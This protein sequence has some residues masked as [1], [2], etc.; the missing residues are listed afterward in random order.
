M[1]KFF[2]DTSLK[3]ES[4]REI[5]KLLEEGRSVTTVNLSRTFR[6]EFAK[7]VIKG[8]FDT[9]FKSNL[10]FVY[11]DLSFSAEAYK[12]QLQAALSE[13][14]GKH[15]LI[16]QAQIIG[17]KAIDVVVLID[18]CQVSDIELFKFILNLRVHSH[19]K[20]RFMF[21]FLAKDFY[22]VPVDNDIGIVYEN[23]IFV[24]Y[25][26][27]T[28]AFDWLDLKS[29]K[30]IPEK[31][32]EDIFKITGGAPKIIELFIRLIA[33]GQ[34]IDQILE[35]EEFLQAIN[36]LWDRFT[37]KEKLVIL[38]DKSE[39][40]KKESEYLKKLNLI[41][42]KG[43]VI[44]EWVRYVTKL[45]GISKIGDNIVI[46]GHN[47]SDKIT[48]REYEFLLELFE[49]TLVTKE[50]AEELLLSEI[51]QDYSLWAVDQAVKRLRDK[52]KGLGLNDVII[53]TVKGKGYQLNR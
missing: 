22:K 19:E 26:D 35:S 36:L 6:T 53:K 24:P 43:R 17:E 18:N 5:F 47:L 41:D 42:D 38:G 1:T 20:I 4:A 8:D 31:L 7:D 27:K 14:A 50:K 39:E 46:N 37:A 30:K 34:N 51:S 16:Q 13:Y 45:N 32:K 2:E 9:E 25:L 28:S 48:I 21:M 3:I 23:I 33:K 12:E 49:S 15:E 44:G 11:S 29:G 52:L 10:K 40:L